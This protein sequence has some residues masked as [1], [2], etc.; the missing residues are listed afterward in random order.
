MA[1]K[2]NDPA[3]D[4]RQRCLPGMAELRSEFTL[5]RTNAHGETQAVQATFVRPAPEIA[6]DPAPG[7]AP[8]PAPDPAPPPTPDDRWHLGLFGDT[9]LT[10]CGTDREQPGLRSIYLRA[11]TS[12]QRER[13]R[14]M[15]GELTN[16][17]LSEFCP[18]CWPTGGDYE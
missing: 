14:R 8:D 3:N 10:F 16:G 2:R 13:A 7:R 15:V 11:D 5:T 6:P 12:Q 1:R 17:R 4:L 18:T 9:N